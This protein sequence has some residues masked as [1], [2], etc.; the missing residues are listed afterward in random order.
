MVYGVNP[1]M[2]LDL[3][4]LPKDE[5]VHKCVNDKSKAMIKLH[6]QVR[7]KIETVNDVYKQNS[8]IHTKPCVFQDG[9]LI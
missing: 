8:N 4:P 6:Q 5:L 7:V 1:Y 3:I 2:P 9:D